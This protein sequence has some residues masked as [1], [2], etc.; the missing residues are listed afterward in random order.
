M[1]LI[2]LLASLSLI[3][4]LAL[5]EAEGALQG[6]PVMAPED[7]ENYHFDKQRETKAPRVKD[8]NLGQKFILDSNRQNIKD[9][10]T[11]R[12][13]IVNIKQDLGDLKKIQEVVDRKIIKNGDVE[14]WQ[15]LG[16]VFGDVLVAELDLNWVSYEDELG[17]SK[18]LQWKKTENYVFPVTMLSKRV[19]YKEKVDV[20]ALFE[21][22]KL[23]VVAMERYEA[24]HG[25][26]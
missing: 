24:L 10:M 18:A 19:Q 22:I 26:I 15:A 21:Q 12:L 17:S 1:R 9:L 20:F 5:G 2:L 4:V 13:G 3:P 23:D 8:L 7:L 11:R 16:V 14:Q 25:K 6:P